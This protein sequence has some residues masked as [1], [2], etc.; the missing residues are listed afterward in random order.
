[1]SMNKLSKWEIE[2]IK[3]LLEEEPELAEK[4]NE[5]LEKLIRKLYIEANDIYY[6]CMRLESKAETIR[7]YMENR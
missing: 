3:E 6:E 4:T 2:D 5:E 1:M 7:K